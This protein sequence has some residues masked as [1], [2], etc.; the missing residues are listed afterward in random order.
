MLSQDMKQDKQRICHGVHAQRDDACHR[1]AVLLGI[2]RKPGWMLSHIIDGTKDPRSF[3]I[4]LKGFVGVP[5]DFTFVNGRLI[6]R[7]TD[8]ALGV[9]NAR[10]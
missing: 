7:P 2:R 10:W 4:T 9:I 8:R 1:V 6:A 5:L 3:N